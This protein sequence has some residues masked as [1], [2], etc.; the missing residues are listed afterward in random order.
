MC[1]ELLL[2]VIL[3]YIRFPTLEL[4]SITSKSVNSFAVTVS[5]VIFV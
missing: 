5:T 2:A 4:G 3:S 1:R